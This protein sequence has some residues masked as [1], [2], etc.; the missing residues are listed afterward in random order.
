MPGGRREGAGRKPGAVSRKTREIAEACPGL[1]ERVGGIAKQAIQLQTDDVLRLVL[2]EQFGH[3]PAGW[4][5]GQRH[6]TGHACIGQQLDQL[7]AAQAG[8]AAGPA[9]AAG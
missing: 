1:R 8:I 9:L 4:P 2:L 3:A 7:E 5:L 6:R